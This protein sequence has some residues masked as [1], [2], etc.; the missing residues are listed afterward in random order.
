MVGLTEQMK[1][2]PNSQIHQH[3][4]FIMQMMTSISFAENPDNNLSLI[5]TCF[6]T[7]LNILYSYSELKQVHAYF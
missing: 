1:N 3:L 4:T 6:M 2:F 5:E 7:I